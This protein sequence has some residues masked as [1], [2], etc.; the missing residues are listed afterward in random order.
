MKKVVSLMIMAIVVLFAMSIAS[1]AGTWQECTSNCSNQHDPIWWEFCIDNC[2]NEYYG[3]SI[4]IPNTPPFT[5]A[6]SKAK[7]DTVV[8]SVGDLN[9][10][11]IQNTG[12]KRVKKGPVLFHHKKHQLD[13][14]LA[15]VECHHNYENG[16]N[17]WKRGDP[18]ELCIN[19]HNPLKKQGKIPKLEIAFHKNCKGCHRDLAKAGK[20]A[21]PYKKCNQC[22][23]KKK[24]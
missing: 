14:K 10:I 19:C 8:A 17:I 1:Y 7:S 9:Q 21:G 2:L 20:K 18:V 15:C 16:K 6:S 22:H 23:Q 13:Y 24:K 12:Y 11:T 3:E 4:K 5:L